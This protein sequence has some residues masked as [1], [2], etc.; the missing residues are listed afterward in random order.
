[1]PHREQIAN[2]AADALASAILPPALAGFDGF[3]DSI[4][5]MVDR[6][7]DMSRNG[8]QRL[9]TIA[10]FAQRCA[11]AAG[12]S[13]N[14]EQVLLQDRFGGNGPLFAGALARLGVPT[15]FIGA[16][17]D[18]N[19]ASSIHPVFREFASWCARAVPI[20]PP[21][22]TLCAEFDDGKLMFNETSAVQMVTW[23][24][25]VSVVG[26]EVLIA[27]VRASSLFCM[28][29]WSLLGGV[30]GI[31][32]GLIRD[33]IPK[34]GGTRR[35]YI[36]LSD[37]AKR[38]NADI[39]SAMDL[40]GELAATKGT[41]LTLGLNLAEAERVGKAVCVSPPPLLLPDTFADEL[42]GFASRLRE[43]LHVDTVV[44]HPREG[45][46]A[47]SSGHAAWFDGPSTTTPRLSTG[48]GDHFNAGFAL[49]Q[50][51]SLPLEQCLAVGTSTSGVYVRDAASPTRERLVSFLR[52]L[53]EPELG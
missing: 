32:K 45:A 27:H 14:I 28:N 7:D 47:A 17:A 1:M 25:L 26:L 12:R 46:A 49:A 53:P 21:S 22:V 3:V 52:A 40:L 6:R 20:A 39:A 2:A 41:S 30:P 29:N 4:V 31:W 5:H 10:A 15:T 50:T 24:R 36:D 38:T 43:V 34:A 48:A 16:I 44:I 8:Y 13:T 35:I 42:P 9:T 19:N 18:P 23:D 51:L 37:P 11:A 33:V